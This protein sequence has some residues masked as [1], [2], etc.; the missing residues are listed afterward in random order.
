MIERPASHYRDTLTDP[1]DFVGR[2]EL[3]T[4][5]RREPRLLRVLLGGRRIGKSSLLRA[6]EWRLLR[7]DLG[8]PRRAFPVYI[9]LQRAEPRNLPHF[10]FMLVVELR[11]AIARW[12]QTQ[13]RSGLDVAREA[14]AAFLRRVAEV[15]VGFDFLAKVEVKVATGNTGATDELSDDGFVTAMVETFKELNQWQFE[16]VCF[17]IDEAEYVIR[18]GWANNAWPYFRSLKSSNSSS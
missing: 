9:D 6:I 12:E 11:Q 1:E 7:P 16:G 3:L 17:L 14:Y 18:Q 5:I 2:E 13:L 4:Q 15:K 10:R 8:S